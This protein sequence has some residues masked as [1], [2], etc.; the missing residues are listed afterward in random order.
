MDSCRDDLLFEVDLIQKIGMPGRIIVLGSNAAAIV[1]GKHEEDV[2][3]AAGQLGKG[4]ICAF[5]HGGYG[6]Q[7]CD[8]NGNFPNSILYRNVRNWVAGKELSDNFRVLK[9]DESKPQKVQELQKYDFLLS[10]GAKE[11]TPTHVLEEYL[12]AGGGLVYATTPW[13]W[14]QV[15]QG[16]KAYEVPYGKILVDV[17]IVFSKGMSKDHGSGF[18]TELNK[19]DSANVEHCFSKTK[20]DLNGMIDKVNLLSQVNDLPQQLKNKFK[21]DLQNTW[22]MVN[23][24]V[25][26]TFHSGIIKTNNKPERK[27]LDLWLLCA[28]EQ[29]V[30]NFKAPAITHF[31]GDFEKVPQLT[32]KTVKFT[33]ER[34]DFYFSSCYLPAGDVVKLNVTKLTDSW[35]VIVGA[36]VDVLE[37]DDVNRWPDISWKTEIIKPGAKELTN[38]FG[39]SI[40][41]LS[42]KRG[43]NTIEV[44]ING[45]AACPRFD[46]QSQGKPWK[47]SRVDPGLWAD[48][49]GKYMTVTLPS[50]SIRNY[51]DP[52]EVMELYDQLL[53]AYHDLR[54]SNIDKERRMWIVADIQPSRGYMHAGY[55]IVTGLDVTDPKKDN[56]LLNAKTFKEHG[57]WGV[58]HEIGHNMQRKEWTFYGTEEVTVNIFTLYGMDVICGIDPWNHP[59]LLEQRKGTTSYLRA[60]ADFGMWKAVPGIA[61][62][63]YAQLAHSFTWEAYKRVFRRYTVLHPYHKPQSDQDK[64]DLWFFIFSDKTKFN[65]LPV[66]IFWGIPISN[67]GVSKIE[68]LKL[69][70]FL[71]DDE[72]TREVPDRVEMVKGRF[73]DLTRTP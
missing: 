67:G 65:L 63:L 16:K 10:L 52:T 19:A 23:E 61:L 53:K 70:S 28:E 32:N 6:K 64:I 26:M 11:T 30:E 17:G 34:E 9:L 57:F 29:P 36:H 13:G 42:P 35:T 8:Q 33:S 2:V 73:P 51:D 46:S 22:K 20:N 58:F 60:G 31:P 21:K 5:A 27:L 41:F 50:S 24:K 66:A 40:Y 4:R 59:W 43:Q 12:K 71:P 49:S 62:H 7:L 14:M 48:I 56:F 39:G 18:A 54:G 69:K 72:I 25:A 15:N 1:T 44:T 68:A 3:L 38:P 37:G 45:I 55:P 47:E